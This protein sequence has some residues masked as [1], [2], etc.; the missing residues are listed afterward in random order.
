M[1][2][3]ETSMSE[4][5]RRH[6]ANHRRHA[7]ARHRHGARTSPAAVLVV[8]ALACSAAVFGVDP[9]PV[10]AVDPATTTSSARALVPLV[11][12]F[13]HDGKAID[14]PYFDGPRGSLMGLRQTDTLRVVDATQIANPPEQ[15]LVDVGL[16][17]TTS[18][19]SDER[20]CVVD[21]LWPRQTLST[22]QCFQRPTTIGTFSGPGTWFV[23]VPLT[24]SS[25]AGPL[26][27]DRWEQS[28][29][30][31]AGP[32]RCRT[33]DQGVYD[34]PWT[35]QTS[36]P[37]AFAT[38]AQ[39]RLWMDPATGA[40]FGAEVGAHYAPASDTTPDTTAP[41]VSITSPIDC[42]WYPQGAVVPAQF[43]CREL[44]LGDGLNGTG[45]ASCA[46]TNGAAQV[47]AGSPIDTAT[48]G[49]KTLT[50]TATDAAG[51][52]RSR[53][54]SYRIDGAAPEVKIAVTP[55]EPNATGWFSAA[56]LGEGGTLS[57]SATAT[58]EAGGSSISRFD[59]A[60]DGVETRATRTLTSGLF[61]E[62]PAIVY[63][64]GA[65]DYTLGSGEHTVDCSATDRS[66]QTTTATQSVKVDTKP[67]TRAAAL[68]RQSP[69][70]TGCPSISIDGTHA[71][72]YQGYPYEVDYSGGAD[73]G[74][75][76]VVSGSGRMD[77]DVTTAGFATVYAPTMIDAAGNETP[78]ASC[79][80]FVIAT[81]PVLSA[82]GPPVSMDAVNVAKAGRTIP[83]KFSVTRAGVAVTDLA[84]ASV[85]V[86]GYECE[87]G[88]PTDVLEAASTASSSGLVNLGGGNYQYDVKSAKSWAGLCF[89]LGVTVEGVDMT[90]RFAFTR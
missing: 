20:T 58:D 36:N 64:A 7:D 55:P 15:E 33:G 76:L 51:N 18:I 82:F 41:M 21:E 89:H 44:G 87:A 40:G 25:P 71:P 83:F 52:S 3:V 85:S 88:A 86:S 62:P 45:V 61:A 46:A 31:I 72:V 32:S 66:G 42:Y 68:P 73:D 70:G 22:S 90:A 75:G 8:L 16:P 10:G 5:R 78:G 17:P 12:G 48:A 69:N 57:L 4:R 27:F 26:V 81:A 39:F 65:I 63:T 29:S 54:I 49:D 19:I 84:T 43:D 28:A 13:D 56:Q 50:V 2:Q 47:P 67:P 23:D 14:L 79:T 9:A 80:Y 24:V 34:V 59:C 37:N 74:S 38:A 11:S 6:F 35:G 53:T 77:L 30:T 60:L 1:T